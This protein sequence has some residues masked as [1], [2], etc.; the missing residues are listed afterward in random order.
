MKL[1]LACALLLI[2]ISNLVFAGIETSKHNLSIGGP[3]T[4]QAQSETEICIFCHTPHNSVPSA[5]LWNRGNSTQVYTP[6]SSSTMHSTPGQPTGTSILCLSCHDG[7]IAIGSVVVGGPI[8]MNGVGVDATGKLLNTSKGYIGINLSDD[9]PISFPF[10]AAGSGPEL[11]DP[12]LL[13]PEVKLDSKNE[14]QCTTCH[15]AHNDING[16]FLVMNNTGSALCETCHQKSLWNN[17]PHNTSTATWNGTGTNPWTHGT[18]GVANVTTV[19]EK[20]CSNCHAAH[21]APV[22]ERLF[23]QATEED[24]CYVCHDGTVTTDVMADFAKASHH[25]VTL[26]NGVH[27]PYMSGQES[28]PIT[29]RHVECP[30]C[31]NAHAANGPVDAVGI[32][33]TDWQG[34]T[35]SPVVKK[36]YLCFKCHAE[37]PAGAVSTRSITR[38]MDQPNVRL[39]FDPTNN[40]YHPVN[41]A[42][43]RTYAIPS[44]DPARFPPGV[45]FANG[46]FECHGDDVSTNQMHGSKWPA[47]LKTQMTVMDGPA[48]IAAYQLCYDCHLSTSI[49]GNMSFTEHNTHITGEST[50]CMT[51]HSP[52]GVSAA[53]GATQTTNARLINF[54]TAIVA[55]NGGVTRFT[56]TGTVA[57]PHSGSCT[58]V[59]HGATHSNCSYPGG[60][61]A[62]P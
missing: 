41:S 61:G 19:A 53:A 13:P 39:E 23:T 25:L 27:Q 30:D 38:E 1:K 58:L 21:N 54:N 29:T 6:Y 49:L 62:C 26:A 60:G 17:S 32:V 7:T 16:Q 45:P 9:H 59:C 24:T 10:T 36:E 5:P 28:P 56:W 37:L 34:I 44:I 42:G 31:H 35:V 57:A 2:A 52:H 3:G 46:C 15:D 22:N 48:S 8:N 51:C 14:L 12:A 11:I 43:P 33:G 18:P 50:S 4:I 47:I 55:P 20:G 40:A